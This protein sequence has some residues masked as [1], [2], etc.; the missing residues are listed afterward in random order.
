M[1]HAKHEN[2]NISRSWDS[3]E[4]FS[5]VETLIKKP[6]KYRGIKI[7]ATLKNNCYDIFNIPNTRRKMYERR[8]DDNL[9]KQCTW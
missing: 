3:C 9:R 5:A 7:C 6:D 4:N 2:C 1:T 8:C